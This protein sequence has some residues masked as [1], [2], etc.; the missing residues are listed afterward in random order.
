MSKIET[1]RTQLFVHYAQAMS[2][3]QRL[4]RTLT[5]SLA[6]LSEISLRKLK[7][8][9]APMRARLNQMF[10]GDLASERESHTLY[11]RLKEIVDQRNRL[12]HRFFVENVTRLDTADGL[13]D[14]IANLIEFRRR[15]LDLTEFLT[16]AQLEACLFMTEGFLHI[17]REHDEAMARLWESLL[18]GGPGRRDE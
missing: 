16:R 6:V 1:L 18:E 5:S 15:C 17:Q 11:K 2:A 4:E 12:A 3:V 9:R 14:E 7:E 8:Q 10:A 13:S